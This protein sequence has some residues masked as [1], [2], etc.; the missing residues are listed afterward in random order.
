MQTRSQTHTCMH[1][2]RE[3]DGKRGLFLDFSGRSSTGSFC[4]DQCSATVDS[5]E[6][7]APRHGR[8]AVPENE[9]LPHPFHPALNSG[10]RV[11]AG[12][13]MCSTVAPEVSSRIQFLLSCGNLIKCSFFFFLLALWH[14]GSSFP[15][16]FPTQGRNRIP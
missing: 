16:S 15:T 3:R 9:C 13:R 2:F 14:V 12:G 1:T 5:M 10:M 6:L 4:S 8:P 7:S 11:G